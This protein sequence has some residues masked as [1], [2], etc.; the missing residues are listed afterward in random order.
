RSFYPA[1]VQ[2]GSVSTMPAPPYHS[3]RLLRSFLPRKDVQR[4]FW[5]APSAAGRGQHSK[6]LPYTFTE[7]GCAMLSGILNSGRAIKMNIAIMRAFVAIRKILLQQTGIFI[8]RLR[9]EPAYHYCTSF[10]HYRDQRP[11][12]GEREF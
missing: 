1:W 9:N 3:M 10:N 11:A 8:T 6:Y 7:Q 12:V 4:P 2:S 5:S